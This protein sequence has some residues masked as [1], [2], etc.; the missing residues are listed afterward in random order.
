MIPKFLSPSEKKILNN[1][2]KRIIQDSIQEFDE[3]KELLEE[4]NKFYLG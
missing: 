3:D 1:F 4:I 2:I